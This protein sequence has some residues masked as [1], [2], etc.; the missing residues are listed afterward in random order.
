MRLWKI[1]SGG[2]EVPKAL[3]VDKGRCMWTTRQ[4]SC[5]AAGGA[6][7][8]FRLSSHADQN[9][10]YRLNRQGFGVIGGARRS[11]RPADSD[12]PAFDQGFEVGASA[13]EKGLISMGDETG[14][15]I[16]SQ[17]QVRGL[18]EWREHE[19]L[20]ADDLHTGRVIDS[21]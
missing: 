10:L 3:L 13:I 20:S 4:R 21:S 15:E 19:K 1:L 6:E 16:R 14:F 9:V 18:P 7:K 5:K 8:S 12:V 2:P 11:P 17:V